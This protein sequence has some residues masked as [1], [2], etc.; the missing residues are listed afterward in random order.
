MNG[1]NFKLTVELVES[2]VGTTAT[3]TAVVG[4]AGSISSI[5]L[6][7]AGGGYTKSPHANAPT[8]TISND[9][10][11]KESVLSKQRQLQL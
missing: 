5:T 2:V 6:T 9:N 8:V 10:Q 7:N 4:A 3:G 11:F 1:D